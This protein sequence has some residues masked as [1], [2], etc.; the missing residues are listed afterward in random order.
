MNCTLLSVL[1]NLIYAYYFILREHKLSNHILM[2]K[3]HFRQIKLF[4]EALD[5]MN[6]EVVYLYITVSYH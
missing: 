5:K 1:L 6:Q 4:I 2:R 3:N